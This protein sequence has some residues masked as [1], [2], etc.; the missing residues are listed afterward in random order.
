MNLADF[1]S[2]ININFRDPNGQRERDV[3]NEAQQNQY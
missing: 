3:P 1:L 2:S